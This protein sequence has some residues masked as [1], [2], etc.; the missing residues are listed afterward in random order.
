MTYLQ[1][2]LSAA[3]PSMGPR[4]FLALKD[5]IEII[6]IQNPITL[7]EGMVLDGWHRYRA[8]QELGMRCPE[9][10]IGDV[11]P[12]DFVKA[13]NKER[14]H[15]TAGAWALIEA[16]LWG[17]KPAHRP[18]VD[19]CAP[20]AHL[21]DQPDHRPEKTADDL[22]LSAGV[23]RRT[24]VQAKRVHRDA[25][26][27]VKEAV[28][29]GTVSLKAAE[30]VAAL[31]KEEQSALASAGPEAIKEAARLSGQPAKRRHAKPRK[32][33]KADA[34]R[35]EMKAAKERGVSML[36]TYGRLLLSA[37][38]ATD[39][40]SDEENQLIAEIGK[41]VARAGEYGP[42][43][44]EVAALH[45]AEAA[46]RD[47]LAKLLDSDDK[48]ATAHAELVRLNALTAGLQQRVNGLLNEKAAAIKAAKQN[49][50]KADRLQK[51][52]DA[53]RGAAA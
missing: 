32:G 9:M 30:V 51:E 53:R 3:F 16:E 33:A 2:P 17:W 49:Q 18:A 25:I 44:A 11:D 40:L 52:L 10:Q 27:E 14:R 47:L 15:L 35:D 39:S 4:E 22:A 41:S 1:H 45:A 24:I 48:L 28:K 46:D 20:G 19:K 23:S 42:A 36:C 13:Q 21:I 50:A 43:D 6:G 37:L 29:A 7:Y 31:P 12:V 8:S 5:S 38:D 34:I 26:P